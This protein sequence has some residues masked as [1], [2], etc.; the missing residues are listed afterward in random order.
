MNSDNDI[1]DTAQQHNFGEF[2]RPAVAGLIGGYIGHKL[3]QTRF[4]IWFNNN[5]I[6]NRIYVEVAKLVVVSIAV[7]I[8]W[9]L[10]LLL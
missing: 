7:A 9:F 10:F 5:R 3:D 2:I 1:F 4:G 8:V 6:V